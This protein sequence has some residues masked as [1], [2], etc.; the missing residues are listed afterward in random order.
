MVS[1]RAAAATIMGHGIIIRAF[2]FGEHQHA[3]RVCE[4]ELAAIIAD[5]ARSCTTRCAA[6]GPARE[7]A[8]R[9][10]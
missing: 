9:G 10:N 2:R 1:H 4:R 5:I 6:W 8:P 3:V 7:A